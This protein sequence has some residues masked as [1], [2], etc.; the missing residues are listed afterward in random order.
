MDVTKLQG[1]EV[2]PYKYEDQLA[3]LQQADPSTNMSIASLLDEV[4]INLYKNKDRMF[5][6]LLQN[7]DDAS[8][9]Y[10]VQMRVQVTDNYVIISHNGYPFN[11]DDFKSITSARQ[12]TK[13]N[14]NKILVTRELAL[15]QFSLIPVKC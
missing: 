3:F 13:K 14:K 6:E 12:S 11:A 7:A 9:Q 15:S 1:E 4:G 2:N 10:G 8:A 5:Y